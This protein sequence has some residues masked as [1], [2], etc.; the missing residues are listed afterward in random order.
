MILKKPGGSG[1]QSDESQFLSFIRLVKKRCFKKQASRP[2]FNVMEA[3]MFGAKFAPEL[4]KLHPLHFLHFKL[5][6]N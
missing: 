6:R 1:R 3:G 5:K 2:R 4:V